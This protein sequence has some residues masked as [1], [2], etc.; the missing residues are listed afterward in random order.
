MDWLQFSQKTK[1]KSAGNGDAFQPSHR[2]RATVTYAEATKFAEQLKGCRKSIR[3]LR[4]ATES[5]PRCQPSPAFPIRRNRKDARPLASLAASLPS[6]QNS[7]FALSSLLGRHPQ[8][9]RA[10][11]LGFRTVARTELLCNG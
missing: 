3:T 5:E 4:T 9:R 8:T 2:D 10:Y 1:T 6:L 11:D 7:C